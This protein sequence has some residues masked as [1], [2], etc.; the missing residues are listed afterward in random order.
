MRF[1]WQ[2]LNE[3]P[4]DR[5]ATGNAFWHGRAWLYLKEV[6]TLAWSWNFKSTFCHVRFSVDGDEN[7]VGFAIAL[8]PV[9]LWLHLGGRLGKWLTKLMRCDYHSV[10]GPG[11]DIYCMHREI[12][13]SIHDWTLWSSIWRKRDSWSR[14]D[15]WWMHWSLN[16]PDLFL[17]ERKHSKV[18][19]E[20]RV[21]T[22]AMPEGAYE[23]KAELLRE[24]WKRPRWPW[25]LV[26]L[27]TDVEVPAGI[28]VPGKGEN[29]WDCGPDAIYGQCGPA[30]SI[31][32]AVG[33]LV[34]S[35]LKTRRQRG[36]KADYAERRKMTNVADKW[37][38]ETMKGSESC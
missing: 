38:D 22:V 34:G 15:P 11:R 18:V 7:E 21:V 20:Q 3:L 19:L 28:P 30:E 27:R 2:N 13:F 4:G 33:N 26:L 29:S 23:A 37:R 9:A 1:H 10:A 17:G 16:L 31:E 6:V 5:C 14:D 12:Q 32:E 24:T 35:V 36:A 8:P 25:P